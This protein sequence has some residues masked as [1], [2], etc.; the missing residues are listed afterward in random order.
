MYGIRPDQI[1]F[2]P[3]K[4]ICKGTTLAVPVFSEPL[5]IAYRIMDAEAIAR[6]E[7]RAA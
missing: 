2:N 7:R 5:A 4:G 3:T 1:L 6:A